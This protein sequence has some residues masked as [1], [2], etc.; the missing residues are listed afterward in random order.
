MIDRYDPSRARLI[1]SLFD[2]DFFAGDCIFA[3]LLDQCLN[4]RVIEKPGGCRDYRFIA[5][6]SLIVVGKKS[7]GI[8]L[9]LALLFEIGFRGV[10]PLNRFER[11][12]LPG[13]IL[14]DEAGC[15]SNLDFSRV[16]NVS[17]ICDLRLR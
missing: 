17:I 7:A 3:E 8:V 15:R 6:V 11:G 1:V 14:P 16:E 2:Y 13:L 10:Y 4:L 5:F 12:S 9:G